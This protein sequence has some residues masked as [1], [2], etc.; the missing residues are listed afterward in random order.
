M[1]LRSGASLQMHRTKSDLGPVTCDRT[2]EMRVLQGSLEPLSIGYVALGE[3]ITEAICLKSI[4][5]SVQM[6]VK[7]RMAGLLWLNVLSVYCLW[8]RFWEGNT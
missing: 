4:F 1:I 7:S 5:P 8:A 2:S 6:K 3:E